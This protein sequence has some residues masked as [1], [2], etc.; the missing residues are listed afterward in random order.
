M[1]TEKMREQGLD[2][3]KRI[4]G[5]KINRISISQ[6]AVVHTCMGEAAF[7]VECDFGH[8]LLEGTFG[9]LKFSFFAS[10]NPPQGEEVY[11]VQVEN[12]DWTSYEGLR[13]RTYP[14][15]FNH[16]MFR[17]VITK[18]EIFGELYTVEHRNI[19]VD[20]AYILIFHT[21]KGNKFSMRPTSYR[22]ENFEIYFDPESIE[23]FYT[24]ERDIE[25][26]G[27]YIPKRE[28][29]KLEKKG[30]VFEEPKTEPYFTLR[31][32]I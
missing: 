7:D 14:T 9:C 5:E 25:V 18:I 22:D 1:M 32:V 15:E 2:L 4:K 8:L 20:T 23:S 28:R 16:A 21:E 3:L 10:E 31:T 24:M 27:E 17:D 26:A 12:H 13:Y 29:R 6:N 11:S 19:S 30:V